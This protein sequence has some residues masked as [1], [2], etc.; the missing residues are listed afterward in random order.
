MKNMM[1]VGNYFMLDQAKEF[2]AKKFAEA[3][4]K[5]HFLD[6]FGILKDEFKVE[7]KSVL[8]AGLLHDTL[9]DTSTAYGEIEK[10]FSKKVADLVQE[11]SHP[12][13]YDQ[14]QKEEYYQKI[15]SISPGAKLIK[16]ADFASHLRN[17]IKIYEKGEAHLYPKFANNDRYIAS[18]REFL[19]SCPDS[20]SKK[21]VSDLTNGLENLP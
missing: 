16:M 14:K 5:N 1:E 18:I 17:F 2:A 12:K 8:I 11:V 21:I 13:N 9:E 15:K 10:R 20:E 6:V 4:T 3:G 7:D 19:E